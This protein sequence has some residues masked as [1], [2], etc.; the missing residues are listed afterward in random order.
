MGET[1]T[2]F[3]L[4]GLIQEKEKKNENEE[5]M[6]QWSWAGERAGSPAQ[7]EKLAPLGPKVGRQS[8]WMQVKEGE[9]D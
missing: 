9:L 4:M 8:L 5:L 1:A 6:E 7:M 3:H 2:C